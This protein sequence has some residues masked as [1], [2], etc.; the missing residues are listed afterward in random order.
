MS[1]TKFP[2]IEA[3]VPAPSSVVLFIEN[4]RNQLQPAQIQ[5]LAF[6]N[7]NVHGFHLSQH[8]IKSPHY[9]FGPDSFRNEAIFDFIQYGVKGKITIEF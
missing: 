1:E 2:K 5:L 4:Y 8:N 9:M 7:E 6:L 3:T